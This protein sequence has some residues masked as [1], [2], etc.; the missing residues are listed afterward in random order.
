MNKKQKGNYAE[1][2]VELA[3][4]EKGW[5]ISRPMSVARYDLILDDGKKL[6]RVQVKYAGQGDKNSSGAVKFSANNGPHSPECYTKDEVDLILVYIPQIDKVVRIDPE[7]FHGKTACAI[8]LEPP[9][10]NM[11]KGIFLAEDHVF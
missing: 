6:H 5:I 1:A 2:K 7:H 8:R 10:N 3:A 11:T 9:K 4:L